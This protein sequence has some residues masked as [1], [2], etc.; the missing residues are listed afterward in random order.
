MRLLISIIATA[1]TTQTLVVTAQQF[2]QPT[3]Q[4]LYTVNTTLGTSWPIGD[5]GLGNRVVIPITGGTFSGPRMSGTVTNLG[6]DW[7][8]TD[9]RGV[10]FPDTRYNLRTDDGADIFIRTSGPSQPDGRIF[11]RA[12]YETGH[13]DYEWLNYIVATGVLEPSS[14]GVNIDMWQVSWR[15]VSSY[16]VPSSLSANIASANA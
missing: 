6:A 13:P 11:L 7:G 10:F 14:T 16:L 3:L 5:T 1:F 4:F 2:P 15:L 9:S 12:T 8:V